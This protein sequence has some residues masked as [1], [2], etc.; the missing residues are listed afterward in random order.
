MSSEKPK[1]ESLLKLLNDEDDIA[2]AAMIQLLKYYQ[3]ELDSI[4]KVLQECDIVLLRKRSHQLQALLTFKE[5]RKFIADIFHRRSEDFF[6][7]DALFEFHLL[8]YDKDSVNELTEAYQEL[9]S[10]L[11][12]GSFNSFFEFIEYIKLQ[13]FAVHEDSSAN[14]D[15][16]LIGSV[17]DLHSGANSFMCLLIMA[18]AEDLELDINFETIFFNH[19]FYLYEPE[20]TLVCDLLNNF[21][22]RKIDF[23]SFKKFDRSALFKFIGAMCFSNAVH[24]DAFRYIHILGDMLSINDNLHYLPYPYGGTPQQI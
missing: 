17:L 21:E 6:I 22:I 13:V 4:L 2:G 23:T 16:Y 24:D 8:W 9:V 12:S 7:S 5:R 3:N 20:T 10:S 14:I 1:I 15:L 11:E 19:Q 18:L